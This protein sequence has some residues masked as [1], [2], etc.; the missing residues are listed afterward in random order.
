MAWMLDQ[1][2]E[3]DQGV[4][5]WATTGVGEPVVLL[6]GT[7]YSSF[8]WRD[9]VPALS[10]H[11]QVYVF[12][13]LGF[14]QSEQREGQ[15]LSL[16]AHARRF[17]ALLSQWGLERPS[18]V[19]HDIGGAIALRTTLLE[20][21]PFGDLVLVDAVSGGAWERGLFALLLEH[22][23]VFS[24]LP[25]YAHEALVSSHLRQGTSVGYRP[26][27]METFLEPWRG[28]KGQAAFYRQ[29]R[30]LRQT[31]TAAYESLLPGLSI[32]VRLLWGTEDRILPPP[33]ADWIHERIPHSE[34]H[35]IG[36][37]GHLVQEDAPA[38]L[39]SHLVEALVAAD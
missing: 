27:V 25:S 14:G 39:V 22:P 26:G 13:H 11:R 32:P 33:Y 15:D 20:T 38:Q 36:G 23:D 5:R 4:I 19:G 34:L 17:A 2:F 31:D 16:V 29:Y 30:Q 7:P 18:V 3:T 37:A 8:L 9:V 6:H 24:R 28:V 10:R 12:D 1:E 35:W 21:V